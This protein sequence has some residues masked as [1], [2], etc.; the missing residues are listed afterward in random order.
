MTHAKNRRFEDMAEEKRIGFT[1]IELL[2]VI[3]IIALLAAILFPAF[4]QAREKARSATCQSNLKQLGLAV[5]QYSQDYDERFP[6]VVMGNWCDCGSGCNTSIP[7][8][9]LPVTLFPYT[10]SM[11]FWKCPSSI[12]RNWALYDYGYGGYL[13]EQEYVSTL[14]LANPGLPM[15]SSVAAVKTASTL[16]MAADEINAV[17]EPTMTWAS[18]TSDPTTWLEANQ[19]YAEWL[20]DDAVLVPPYCPN[21]LSVN[22]PGNLNGSQAWP[23]ARHQGKP[24]VLF[25]DGHVKVE[26]AGS[27]FA[28]DVKTD[29]LCMFCNL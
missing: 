18:S 9:A 13:G 29:P 16:V 19:H 1:L 27:M 4:I 3:A 22:G 5:L 23:A 15:T 25:C 8:V 10:K 21:G 24:N 6:M 17:T 20:A 14:G 28:H 11:Q 12:G 26:D 2:V 7:T